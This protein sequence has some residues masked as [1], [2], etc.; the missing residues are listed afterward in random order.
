MRAR[1]AVL[2]AALALTPA[3][4]RGGPFAIDPSTGSLRIVLY[5]EGALKAFGHDHVVEVRGLRGSVEVSASS[6]S[7]S[8]EI[9]A[10]ELEID[11]P[12]ARLAEG[13]RQRVP[14]SDRVKI[15]E[16]M[17]GPKGLEVERYPE[18]SF[19]STR[20][21]PGREPGRWTVEGRLTL[22]GATR[23]L[24]IPVTLTQRPGGYWAE[25]AV[26][27]KPSEFGIKPFSALGGLIK[28]RDAAL[29][30][31]ALALSGPAAPSR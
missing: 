21:E 11:A 8:L 4:A 10:G 23:S 12:E 2:W 6:G 13:F 7:V 24:V 26:A 5:K 29:A 22:H 28:V 3:L 31:F 25:G 15:R 20:I 16:S 27:L 17:R 18:I 9:P 19:A 30:R 14:D 1:A